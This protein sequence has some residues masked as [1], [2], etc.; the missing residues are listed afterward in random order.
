MVKKDH[1]NGS[2]AI[3]SVRNILPVT[4]A[5]LAPCFNVPVSVKMTE[6][7]NPDTL[8]ISN[9][10]RDDTEVNSKGNILNN[11]L[12]KTISPITTTDMRKITFRNIDVLYICYAHPIIRI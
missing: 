9:D 2:E 4:D 6:T 8:N 3:N 11:I 12:L 5:A 7:D 1:A 10:S